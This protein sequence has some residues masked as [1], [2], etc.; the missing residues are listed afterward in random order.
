LFSALYCSENG[1]PAKPIRLMVSLLI[2][3]HLRN[4]SDESIV[5]QWLENMYYLYFSGVSKFL[6]QPPCASTDL[7]MFRNR[8]GESGM[9]L[10][11]KESIRV[12]DEQTPMD[13]TNLVI[14]VDTTVQEKK[15]NLSN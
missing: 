1:R 4:L 5:E 13:K 12:N 11:L 10:I 15:H 8:I 3:K 14:S 7:V 9:E 2:L 6:C